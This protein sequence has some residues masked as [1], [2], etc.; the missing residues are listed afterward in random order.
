MPQ[1]LTSGLTYTQKYAGLGG[2]EGRQIAPPTRCIMFL[3][4][5]P[6]SGKSA[7]VQQI[8]DSYLLNLEGASTTAPHPKC[9]TFPGLSPEGR[10][11]GDDG[12]EVVLR[13]ELFQQKL[14]LLKRLSRE[15]KP[16]PTTIIFDSITA[17]IRLLKEW[18]PPNAK[19]LGLAKEA[20]SEW[21][22]LHGPA[23]YDTLYDMVCRTFRD[24]RN[25]GYGVVIIGHVVKSKVPIGENLIRDDVDL[26]GIGD[27]L[28]KR[29]HDLFELSIAITTAQAVEFRE[30][31]PATQMISGVLTVVE[32]AKRI[33]ISV[34][35]HYLTVADV[36][37]E[38][39]TKSRVTLPER[40]DLPKEGAWEVFEEAYT[41]AM[42]DAPKETSV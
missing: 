6:G 19:A 34:R 10:V 20:A 39:L 5:L 36:R 42:F 13:W 28:W 35:K 11:L 32:K 17:M 26:S 40:I 1:T 18:V 25:H 7:F 9:V 23:A 29:L 4:G 38:G 33:P 15:N 21:K 8:P 22:E 2:Y 27:G 31:P 16:R 14:D 12:K 24:L 30:V 41:K 37:L 3:L